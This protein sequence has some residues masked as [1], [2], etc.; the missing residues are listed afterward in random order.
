MKELQ[1]L[2]K[3][4]MVEQAAHARRSLD[5]LSLKVRRIERR[6]VGDGPVMLGVF[7]QGT[8]QASEC[9]GKQLAEARSYAYG[10]E[11]FAGVSQLAQFDSLIERHAEHGVAGFE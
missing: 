10:L 8:K 11:R 7:G 3:Q 9:L 2:G 5:S 4:H 6:S 1:P